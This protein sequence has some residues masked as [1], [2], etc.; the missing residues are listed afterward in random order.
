MLHM[1]VKIGSARINEKGT[2]NGGMAGDQTKKE[3]STQDWYLH[4]KG[5]VVIRA[6]DA[7]VRE[8]IA[9]NMDSIC[10]NDN[11]G[12]CQNHRNTLTIAAQPYGYD[13]SKVT[14]KVEVDCSE[15]VRNCVLYAGIPV[16]SFSTATEASALKNTGEFDVL[17]DGMYC[18][19]S[20]YLVRGDI[21]VTGTKGHTA[22]ALS[23]GAKAPVTTSPAYKYKVGDNVV[24]SSHYV[25]AHDGFDKAVAVNPWLAMQIIGIVEG[26]QNLYHTNYNTYCNDGD[27]RGYAATVKNPALSESKYY[28]GIPAVF[29]QDIHDLQ[30]ALNQDGITDD[31]GNP[32]KEDGEFGEKT[33]QAV[34]KVILS[35]NTIHRHTNVTSWVQCRIGAVA[36][37]I[38]GSDTKASTLSYQKSHGL[39]PDGAVGKDTIM[40]I[41]KD[42]AV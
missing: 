42:V 17:T 27:I 31:N 16:G 33:Y 2:I 41:I 20:D 37:G 11:I 40:S 9:R 36:D 10:A 35:V 8:K 29:D 14:K 21:L 19:S 34:R 6:K 12:Y 39:A 25:G 7:D 18:K 3:V 26:A 23:N 4:S 28:M 15:A 5:W 38:F 1:A 32:L 13:A 30:W 22:V 24:V